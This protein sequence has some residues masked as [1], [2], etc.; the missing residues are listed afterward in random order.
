MR[1]LALGL[2]AL[3]L[4]GTAAAAAPRRTAHV[5]FLHGERGAAVHR[6]VPAR[7]PATAAVTE[8]LRGPSA[9]ERARG[10]TTAVPAGTR[11]LGL[12]VRG[13]TATV[14]LSRRFGSGGGSASMFARLGQLVYTLT[15]VPHVQRV[16][17][18]I[19]GRTV[20]VFGTEGLVLSQ[21]LDRAALAHFLR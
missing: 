18:R 3:A 1:R 17:L 21:P 14:D 11:L 19:E 7:T 4:A 6:S 12:T 8:L 9:P 16:T 13:G 10:L 15:A 5:Y 2:L 20:R